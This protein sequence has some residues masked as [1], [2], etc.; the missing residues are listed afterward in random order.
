MSR[1]SL[2]RGGPPQPAS[3]KAREN[4]R[5]NQ[6]RRACQ[7]A[8]VCLLSCPGG[9]DPHAAESRRGDTTGSAAVRTSPLLFSA[10]AEHGGEGAQ[11]GGLLR[12]GS[13][14]PPGSRRRPGVEDLDDA[15]QELE[16]SVVTQVGGQIG[17]AGGV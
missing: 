5:E 12:G 11:P 10:G 17:A 13:G 8:M 7:R 9:S 6:G 4:T 15:L 3:T 14:L 1:T 2:T 16:P